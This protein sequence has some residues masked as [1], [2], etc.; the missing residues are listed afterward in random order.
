MRT[1]ASLMPMFYRGIQLLS[2]D[3]IA[4][5]RASC[6]DN[7]FRYLDWVDPKELVG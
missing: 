5:L 1:T 6:V 2:D 4:A 3:L 7:F